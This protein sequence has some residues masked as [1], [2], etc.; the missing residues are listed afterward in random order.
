MARG[1][2]YE[3]R[4]TKL[5]SKAVGGCNYF[6]QIRLDPRVNKDF[7]VRCAYFARGNAEVREADFFGTFLCRVWDWLISPPLDS[8]EWSERKPITL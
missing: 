5:H 4:S 1:V 8:G 7:N 3:I 2:E 6:T